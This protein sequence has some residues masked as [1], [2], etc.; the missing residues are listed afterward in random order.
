MQIEHIGNPVGEDAERPTGHEIGIA[1]CRIA[2]PQI[3]I[4]GR[5]AADIDPGRAAGDFAVRNAGVFECV[6]DKFE[7]QPLLRI[8]LRGFSRRDPE[9][10]RFKQVDAGQQ[11]G[12]PGIA[13]AALVLVRVV[14]KA[15]RPPR[16]V[17]LGDS[18]RAGDEQLPER[19]QIGRAGESAGGADDRDQLVTH[20]L[21]ANPLPFMRDLLGRAGRA[22]LPSLHI[23]PPKGQFRGC[24]GR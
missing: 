22:T 9:K 7:E 5:R 21:E 20:G 3:A 15:R 1:G 11:P 12:R 18:I 24:A 19:L 10:C 14:I 4:V 8:H 16:L 23:P 6:P 2:Q 17:D 13:L